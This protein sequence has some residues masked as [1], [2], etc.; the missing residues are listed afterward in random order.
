[1]ISVILLYN[2]NSCLSIGIQF[3]CR[4]AHIIWLDVA[5]IMLMLHNICF[6][7]HILYMVMAGKIKKSLCLYWEC[8]VFR[9]MSMFKHFYS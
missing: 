9:V 3:F 7:Y 4:Y 6:G 8:L 1:M 2:I 5:V